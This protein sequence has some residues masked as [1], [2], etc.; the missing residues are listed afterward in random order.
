MQPPESALIDAADAA[1]SDRRARRS[2]PNAHRG[3]YVG[4]PTHVGAA[5]PSRAP[6]RP[7]AGPAGTHAPPPIAALPTPQ[8]DY[9]LYPAPCHRPPSPGGGASRR[10]PGPH[11]ALFPRTR[12]WRS[13]RGGHL[14]WLC[15]AP[16]PGSPCLLSIEAAGPQTSAAPWVDRVQMAPAPCPA[17]PCPGGLRTAGTSWCS[18]PWLRKG[19]V[20]SF[21]H[22]SR[23]CSAPCPA[24]LVQG[25]GT[26]FC[27]APWLRKGP[28]V[29]IG[30]ASR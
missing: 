29:S 20:A 25:A 14:R 15:P 28:V 22:A 13:S 21:G 17:C 1:P 3:R 12:Q 27:T 30:H 11:R 4:Q 6:I 7:A 16:Q 5:G 24:L 2:T 18:E 10:T 8:A 9:P 23:Y 26:G 19:P